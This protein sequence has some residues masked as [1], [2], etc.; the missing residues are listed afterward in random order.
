M[1]K[2]VKV[3]IAILLAT[4]WLHFDQLLLSVPLSLYLVDFI[5]MVVDVTQWWSIYHARGAFV[6]V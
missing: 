6:D 4:R 3:L 2:V 5:V 1:V